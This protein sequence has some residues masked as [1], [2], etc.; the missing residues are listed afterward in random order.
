MSDVEE[1]LRVVRREHHLLVA[2]PALHAGI[3]VFRELQVVADP[4]DGQ[5][6]PREVFVDL[7][8]L[9]YQPSVSPSPSL[10]P[11]NSRGSGS[12]SG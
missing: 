6:R 7:Q 8:E 11:R 2:Q 10:S 12:E 3:E 1:L 4:D 9:D 5:L